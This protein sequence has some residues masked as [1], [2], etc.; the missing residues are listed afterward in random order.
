MT[1]PPRRW[2]LPFVVSLADPALAGAREARH[3]GQLAKKEAMP[4]MTNEALAMTGGERGKTPEYQAILLVS[5]AHFVN[6]FQGMVLPPLF[7][8]L[9]ARLGIGFFELGLA[10]T[11]ASIVGVL[12]QLPVGY[13]VD[14]IGSRRML[15]LGL[16]VSGLA[17]LGFG[18]APSYSSLL[19]AMV[20]AGF[21]NAV[22]H[23]ADYALLSRKIEPVRL[24]RAFSIH[25]FAGF[26]GTAIAPVTMIALAAGI[27][28]N[29]ALMAAGFIALVVAVPLVLARGIDSDLMPLHQAPPGPGRAGGM[30]AILTPT[31]IGLTGFFALMS[32]SG[33]GISNFSVVALTTAFGTSL[34]VANLALTAYL[35][36]QALGVLA[37]G[38]VADLT[39]RHAEVAA[40]GYAVNAA[41]VL[42]IGTMGLAPAPLV[43]AMAAAGLLGGMIMP[44]RDM[45]VRAAAPPGAMGRAFG[46]VTSGFGMG[47]MVGP[48]MF[49]F[50]M[51]HGAPQWV[52]G[53]S[54]ILMIAVAVVALVSDRRAA[55]K[56]RRR[57][58]QPA[59]ASAD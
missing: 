13:L 10:L 33:S 53:I 26:L 23:P 32:L 4:G 27:G 17:Y 43:V 45:L 21:A 7:L 3:V 14:R 46:I 22:F 12:A 38:F 19:L 9:T 50:A 41:I 39:R 5:S 40:V 16:F 24:G 36:A 34:S 59:A 37:G 2:L 31:I 20:F 42:A 25:T 35:G 48:L 55:A 57:A 15:V 49:G 47:G 44:S 18:L 6:H 56:R 1:A 28:L 58:G 29:F 11:V 30:T 8:L 54:V 52:F 51:D